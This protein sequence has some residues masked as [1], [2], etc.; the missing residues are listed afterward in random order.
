MQSTNTVLLIE[1]IAFG[2]NA[3]TALNN[4]F[5]VNDESVNTQSEALREFTVLVEKLRSSGVKVITMKDT[6]KP[7]TPDSI[8]PNNWVS[9]HDDGTVILYPMFAENRRYERRHDVFDQ[10]KTEG[11]EIV[12][13]KDYSI[14]EAE[15]KY[16]EGTGSMILDRVNKIAYGTVSLRLN[17]EIFQKWCKEFSYKPIQFHSFQSVN[18]KR[19]PIYHTNVMMCVA[20]EFAVIC[21]DTIDNNEERA[22]VEVALKRSQK[23]II[24]IS[25][26][27]MH[28]FAGNMLEVRNDQG[29]PFLVMSECAYKCLTKVQIEKIETFT[30][31]IYSDLRTIEKNGGGSARCMLAEVFLPK[32][33]N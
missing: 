3:Q 4:Y 11:F 22:S 20:S 19:L 33:E 10:L 14:F 30:A 2:F 26:E 24:E 16:L 12:A 23:E 15:H 13:I 8:F 6:L 7:H 5:Q 31:I 1:P 27:Q 29:K 17:E 25:E 9:F 18:G 32:I 21:L 28:N